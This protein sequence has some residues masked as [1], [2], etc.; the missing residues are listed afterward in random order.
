MDLAFHRALWGVKSNYDQNTAV[1]EY[2]SHRL[3]RL[4]LQQLQPRLPCRAALLLQQ[5]GRPAAAAA[6]LHAAHWPW[7]AAGTWPPGCCCCLARCPLAL[8]CCSYLAAAAALRCSCFRRPTWLWMSSRMAP[9]SKKRACGGQGGGQYKGEGMCV[10]GKLQ[11]GWGGGGREGTWGRRQW[12]TVADPFIRYNTTAT[13]SI[14]S[15]TG[16]WGGRRADLR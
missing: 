5:L 3:T 12:G 4:M 10:W 1:V 15:K 14:Q 7:P 11:G 6:A 16:T 8:A 13:R 2:L 9:A